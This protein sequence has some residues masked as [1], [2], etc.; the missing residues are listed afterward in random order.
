M[1]QLSPWI[2]VCVLVF[3]AGQVPARDG[4]GEPQEGDKYTVDYGPS[5]GKD[6]KGKDETQSV[7]Y[8]IKN[9]NDP[10]PAI[11]ENSAEML[12]II[13][14]VEA[15]PYLI[16]ALR[17]KHIM[18]QIKAHGSLNKITGMNF[19]YKNYPEWRKWWEDNGKD[20]M[21][22][23]DKGPSD[24]TRYGA[25]VS[26][27]QGLIYLD[28]RQF[29]AAE[30]MFLDAVN[31][32]PEKPDYRNNLGLAVM[33][34]GR[35]LDAM[36]YFEETMGLND[37]LPQPYMNI[38][39]CY[40]RI[41]RDIEAQTWFRKAMDKDKEGRLWEPLWSLGKDYLKKGDFNMAY[42][43]LDQA[44]VR[45]EKRRKFD[46]RIYRDLAL[47]HYAL[48]QYHSAWKEIKNVEALH[49]KLDDGFVTKVRK[50][51]EAMGVDPDKEEAEARA[52]QF[53]AEREPPDESQAAR[54]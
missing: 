47:T 50:A 12:G 2:G 43:F 48:D 41:N 11:R 3:A 10:D 14:A 49:Y 29:R 7:K 22:K 35:Y 54:P 5:T 1:K 40:S 33:E 51:L 39:Q 52:L 23:I 42:E 37:S 6:K 36:A 19:G 44:R 17:D 18:V 4:N 46:P 32:D 9:L 13:N 53:G 31:R 21:K 8:H 24:A 45:A 26:N 20:F 27:T 34:Q 15:V 38:G 28:S 16:E 30:R 25:Q